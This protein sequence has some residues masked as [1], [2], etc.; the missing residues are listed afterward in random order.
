M[1]DLPGSAPPPQP[2]QRPAGWPAVR[3]RLR[4]AALTNAPPALRRLHN[5]V[6]RSRRAA[7]SM[8]LWVS[9]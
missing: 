4:P 1:Q 7:A 3:E 5:A 6:T 2:R 8:A 9:L